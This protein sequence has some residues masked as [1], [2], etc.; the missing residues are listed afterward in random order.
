M[1][2]TIYALL[3]AVVCTWANA[4]GQT[5]LAVWALTSNG[6]PNAVN[7][8]IQAS[9]FT[10]GNG[11][12]EPTYSASGGMSMGW[13]ASPTSYA[14]D[15]F[16]LCINPKPGN[17]L[18]FNGLEFTEQR[19]A[20]GIRA[21]DLRWSK[22]GFS[23]SSL[24]ASFTIPDD[25][26]PRTNVVSIGGI[27]VCDGETLCLRWYAY[28]SETNYGQWALSNIKVKGT[29]SAACIPPTTQVSSF[30]V[31]N[32]T[33]TTMN[34]SWVRGNGTSVI[35]VARAGAPVEAHPCFTSTFVNSNT[36]FGLGAM[37]GSDAYVVYNSGGTST[38]VT[39]LD[40]GQNYFFTAY[41]YNIFSGCF[42]ESNAPVADATALCA[43]PGAVVDMKASPSGSMAY[44]A[45]D[46]PHCYDE[47][48]V[49][50]SDN[51]IAAVPTS[52]NPADYTAGSVY[53]TGVD[54]HGDFTGSESPVFRGTGRFAQVTGLVN[55]QIYYFRI[56]TFR[57]GS[58]QAGAQVSTIPAS[59]CNSLGD[60]GRVFIN[61]IHFTNNAEDVDEGFELMGP[62]GVDLSDYA[63]LVYK[64]GGQLDKEI[65]P[66]GP[67]DDEGLGYGSI[68]VPVPDIFDVGAVALY[69][70]VADTTVEFL[71]W[72]AASGSITAHEGLAAGETATYIYAIEQGETPFNYSLQRVGTGT[73]PSGM[74]WMGP[75]PATRGGINVGQSV[76]PIELVSFTGELIERQALLS[77]QTATEEQ[78]DYMAVEHSTDARHYT[79]I[80]RLKGAGTTQE[81]QSYQLW[82]TKPQP[83]INY[84]RLRQADFD[85]QVQYYGP[86]AVEYKGEKGQLAVYPT[87]TAGQLVVELDATADEAGVLQVLNLYGQALQHISVPAG[88]FRTEISVSGLPAGQYLLQWRNSRGEQ[89]VQRFVKL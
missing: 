14:A 8:D 24:L 9:H 32:T 82:H 67:I 35:I 11:V 66:T 19:N 38:T 77:W 25:Q 56:Y 87:I 88:T 78:N 3:I 15:Y 49:V 85:G 54:A 31:T 69:N 62:A 41:E 18:V 7:T 13:E 45:W 80:G 40:E 22:D 79:E 27:K 36:Q 48:L 4:L 83:G 28:E 21:Y 44:L 65:Y 29:A 17:V 30:S 86:I 64:L 50:A 42:L 26:V 10:R 46:P 16:E 59:G 81:P 33:A 55:G 73:C 71:A 37:V 75:M 34:L 20:D 23:T 39:G 43:T 70:L 53:G 57:S 51:P 61:E 58:W 60:G 89:E 5:D 6:T 52:S 84:Y 74:S 12:T 72:R 68:W 1:K 76:L 63:L 2:K 47:V